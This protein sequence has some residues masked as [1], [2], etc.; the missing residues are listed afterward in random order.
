[1]TETLEYKISWNDIV[2]RAQERAKIALAVDDEAD[3]RDLVS[4]ALAEMDTFFGNDQYASTVTTFDLGIMAEQTPVELG[5][6]VASTHEAGLHA[7]M[8]FAEAGAAPTLL[9]Y[10]I[11]IMG[12]N[13][14]MNGIEAALDVVAL[15]GGTA[16][17]VFF[18]AYNPRDFAG[19]ESAGKSTGVFYVVQ[20]GEGTERLKEVVREAQ[21]C[22]DIKAVLAEVRAEKE[23]YLAKLRQVGEEMNA[24]LQ[25][26]APE[27]AAEEL[28]R[29]CD[30]VGV[31]DTFLA[32]DMRDYM[33]E[34]LTVLEGVEM[35]SD[36]DQLGNV[37]VEHSGID[38]KISEVQRT[39]G[40]IREVLDSGAYE[41]IENLVGY[42]TESASDSGC[43]FYD[44]MQPDWETNGKAMVTG[45]YVFEELESRTPGGISIRKGEYGIE[46]TSYDSTA[47]E[48]VLRGVQMLIVAGER[49]LRQAEVKSASEERVVTI[50][51]FETREDLH[52]RLYFE[53]DGTR[54]QEVRREME[55]QIAYKELAPKLFR[56][57]YG[58]EGI[59]PVIEAACG[60][61]E[62]GL[63]I[64][65]QLRQKELV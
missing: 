59:K 51:A 17:V 57:P 10:D 50:D 30:R 2:G 11:N 56:M 19:F 60:T 24:Q 45:A 44:M 52:L 14:P 64:R 36:T 28:R 32:T 38:Q 47:I 18:T 3:Q 39:I 5:V 31:Y 6:F 13:N 15:T 27:D 42:L 21:Y 22:A 12:S 7:A 61:S 8:K 34:T 23:L 26:K 65:V 48:H 25:G 58:I 49:A 29:I 37:D 54:A 35:S 1:M 41:R 40:I 53:G 46:R 4:S 16:P 43:A 20:K 33:T 9:V 63:I 55:E 62:Y